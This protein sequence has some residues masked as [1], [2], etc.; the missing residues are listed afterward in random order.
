MNEEKTCA[1]CGKRFI[2]Y[3]QGEECCS[4]MCRTMYRVKILDEQRKKEQEAKMAELDSLQKPPDFDLEHHPRARVEW[5]MSLPD[6]YK[7]RF[8]KFLTPQELEWA[9]AMAQKNL[10]EEKFFSGFYVKNGRI[11]EPK[12]SSDGEDNNQTNNRNDDDDDDYED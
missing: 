12:G 7:V 6:G 11:I 5:F 8:N 4:P 2:P 9:R 3:Q 1:V 10:A